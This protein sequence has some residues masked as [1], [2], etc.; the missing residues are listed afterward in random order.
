MIGLDTAGTVMQFNH[1]GWINFN[2]W[3]YHPEVSDI[4]RLEEVGNGNGTSYAFSEDQ[5]IRSLD[6]G[7][8]VGATNNAD[9][10]TSYWGINTDHR[11]GVLMTE[12]TKDALLEALRERRTYATED[13]N[14]I[15]TMKANGAWMGSEIANSRS[16]LFEIT[17]E[18]PDGE[19]ASRVQII[20]DQ[21]EIAVEVTP[22]TMPFTWQPVLVIT[23]GLHY[24]YARITQADGDLI[25]SS[26]VWTLGSEDIALTD[27][28]IQPSIPTP[29][30]PSMLT[31]RVTNRNSE[32]RTVT[33][34]MDVNGEYLLPNL[35]VSVPGNNDVYANFSWQPI[36]TGAVTVTAHILGAPAG[37]NPDDNESALSLTVT[38]AVLPLILIDAGHGNLN[39]AG[40]EMRMF[41]ADLSDHQYNMLKNLDERTTADRDPNVVKLLIITAP[42]YAYT[43]AE[44]SAISEYMAAGG[45]LWM[46]GLA[47]YPGKVP[48]ADTVANRE[49]AILDT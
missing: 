3:T 16:I 9:T 37:D 27:V 14:F 29:H 42:Q 20:T 13:K 40:R 43:S 48:W 24:F 41:I 31:A 38:E 47:D 23:T 10:H 44:L 33:V 1:P 6:Y 15:L 12:L 35:L 7:W 36:F 28:I 22:G 26:P 18:D 2:D 34:S 11:T 5:Y 45:S 25:V 49:H 8:K 17:G 46:L 32:A 19:L 4:A 39:A 30:N 21:G